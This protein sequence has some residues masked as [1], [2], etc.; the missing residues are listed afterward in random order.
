MEFM[1]AIKERKGAGEP[2]DSIKDKIEEN[3]QANCNE[4]MKNEL[5]YSNSSGGLACGYSYM[6]MNE[7]LEHERAVHQLMR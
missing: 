7:Y 6:C 3:V 5:V 1:R 2:G 4:L